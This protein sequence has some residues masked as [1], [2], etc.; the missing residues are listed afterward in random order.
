MTAS[1]GGIVLVDKPE[2]ATSM[3]V[4]RR[5]RRAMLAGGAPRR[6]RVGHAG[7][8]DPLA[9]GL[10]VV[11]V[12]QATR[13]SGK[14]VALDKE[15]EAV[16]DLACISTTD[17][18]EGQITQVWKEAPVTDR[19][20]ASEGRHAPPDEA[21]VRAVLASFVG[22]I[23]QTPPAYSAVHVGGERAYRLA[24]RGQS[25]PLAPRTV[26]IR[27]IELLAYRWPVLS[28]RVRCG[29]GTYLRSLAR[30]IGRALNAGGMLLALRRTR[31]GPFRLADA[32]PLARIPPRLA[33]SDLYP[34]PPDLLA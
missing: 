20:P 11:L 31:I 17:D 5:V 33:W 18:R 12:G 4:C 28:L 2:G 6:I 26:V 19:S 15:Y 7:T 14:I 13:L 8:L 10:L 16:V 29:K 32:V 23:A 34:P 25:P 27:A 24:R 3:A 21:R 30:D 9:S 1:S 22:R